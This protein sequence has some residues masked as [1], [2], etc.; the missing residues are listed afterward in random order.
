MSANTGTANT[1]TVLDYPYFNRFPWRNSSRP[2]L[3]DIRE[4]FQTM[5]IKEMDFEM[6]ALK[7]FEAAGHRCGCKSLF[8]RIFG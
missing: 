3:N 4:I 7:D 1:M 6:G 8:E 5:S 2:R